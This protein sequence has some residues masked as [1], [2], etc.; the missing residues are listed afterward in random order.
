MRNYKG[1][2]L[3][4]FGLAGLFTACKKYETYPI[5]QV[6]IDRVFD[7]HDSLGTNAGAFLNN[8]YGELLRGHNRISGTD[9]LDAA[10]DDAV[11]SNAAS[12]NTV[13][14]LSNGEYNS[15][16][17]ADP[18]GSGPQ[19]DNLWAYYYQG[20]RMANI[21]IANIGVV[22]VKGS[23]PDGLGTR[24]QWQSEARFL[25]AYFYFELVKR[26]GGV[27]LL[28]NTVYNINDNLVLPRNSF[29]DC[30]TYIVNECNAIKD[31]VLTAPLSSTG[32]YGRVT[33]GAVLALKARVLLYAASPLFNG[34]NIDPTNQFTGYTG[35]V[36]KSR[37]QLAANAAT[38]VIKLGVYSLDT[39]GGKAGGGGFRDV[40][41][42]Q[43]NPEIIFVSLSGSD[44]GTNIEGSNAPV[45]FPAGYALGNTSPTQDLVD[46]YPMQNGLGINQPGSGYNPNNPYINRDPRL[47]NTVFY[48]GYIWLQTPLQM[49]Q[50]GQSEPNNGKTESLTGYYMQKFMGNSQ[51]SPTFVSHSED[52]VMF[53]YAEILLNYAEAENEYGSSLDSAYGALILVRQRA[54][55][56]AGSG[57]YG[58]QSSGSISQDSLRSA[59]QNERRLEFAFEEQRF[60][61]IRRWKIAGDGPALMNKPR[62]GVVITNQFG[63]LFYNYGPVLPGTFPGTFTSKR[64]LYPIPYDEVVKDPQLKQNPGW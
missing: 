38:A 43:N 36:V 59:I 34:G 3:L 4:L 9:Y 46:A 10:S 49:Y 6:N 62:R 13:T 44:N 58:L 12:G 21:F 40:F 61:D 50:G 1:I 45:G 53:R 5:D 19:D 18:T 48:N 28:G 32:N 2:F 54:G 57:T 16:T 47:G 23:L 26:Y 41:L 33:Q 14:L 7:P 11:S 15:G 29:A 17:F 8:I 37:W 25:R 63:T 52:W 56:A 55:I 30:I 64:Y 35:S 31:S 51:N 20:I 22:P 60:F 24:W 27:P 42:T 39:T